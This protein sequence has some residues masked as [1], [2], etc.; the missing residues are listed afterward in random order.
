[1]SIKSLIAASVLAATTVSLPAAAAVIFQDNFDA[2]NATSAL[3]F[4]SLINWTVGD[5]S[6]DYIRSGDYSINCVGGTGGCLDMDGTTSDAGRITSRQTFTFDAGVGYYLDFTVSGNQR[7][8]KNDVLFVGLF[9]PNVAG[10]F[11]QVTLTPSDPFNTMTVNFSEFP[12]TWYLFFEG[13]G[14]DNVGPILDDVVL[15]DDRAA[16][17]EPATLVL[18]GLGLAGLAASR[19]RKQ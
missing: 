9:N 15:R 16:V 11:A 10:V 6:I 12:G 19:R 1:M 4:N 2:D 7:G 14:S 17:P 5:G 13:L 3:N 8:G 18:L